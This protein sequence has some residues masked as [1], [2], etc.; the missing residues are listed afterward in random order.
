MLV[1]TATINV[2]TYIPAMPAI[3]IDIGTSPAMVQ[4][5]LAVFMWGY[6]LGQLFVGPLSDRY[7]RIRVLQWGLVSYTIINL[8]SAFTAEIETLL[9]LR[10]LQGLIAATGPVVVRAILNDRLDS[11]AAARTLSST[12]SIMALV[13][14]LAPIMSG[15]LVE[16][17]GWQSIFVF[18][19]VFCITL[20]ICTRLLLEESLPMNS[21]IDAIHPVAILRAYWQI[22]KSMAFW[23]YTFVAAGM[24]CSMFAYNAVNSFLIINELGFA[25]RYHGMLFA[26]SACAFIA[27]SVLG[28]KLSKST[29]V[30]RVIGWGIMIAVISGAASWWASS[31]TQISLTLVLLPGAVVFFANGLS[32]PGALSQAISTSPH[33]RGSASA[34]VGFLQIGSAGIVGSIA[35]TTYDHTTLPLHK[36]MFIAALIAALGWYGIRIAKR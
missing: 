30:D 31:V 28:N 32:L 21:R 29:S 20:S 13:P 15:F 4:L 6:A 24:F 27:G 12:L 14:A 2:N 18:T 33:R 1:G 16:L 9:V 8:I 3:G 26:L 35:G 7:G 36:L 25:P 19:A 11:A 23:R 5:S 10:A 17:F 34:L 22:G